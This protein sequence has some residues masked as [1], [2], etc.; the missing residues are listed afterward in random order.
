MHQHRYRYYKLQNPET[1]PIGKRIDDLK[2]RAKH[3][4]H[5][6]RRV[7]DRNLVLSKILKLLCLVLAAFPSAI[8]AVQLQM[9]AWAGIWIPWVVVGCGF[10][11]SVLSAVQLVIVD[12]KVSVGLFAVVRDFNSVAEKAT[13]LE[14]VGKTLGEE[15]TLQKL[16]A[17]H[18]LYFSL[19]DK[20][21]EKIKL[22]QFYY[23]FWQGPSHK[24]G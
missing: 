3:Y 18:A 22:N 8:I 21:L 20:Y 24:I 2:I 12:E 16:E 9:E 11:V 15:Q 10:L 5:T 1:A 7:A 17:L 14:A 6:A 4:A 23:G 19:Q 13:R